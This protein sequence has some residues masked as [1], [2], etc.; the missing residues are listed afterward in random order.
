[1]HFTMN[2]REWVKNFTKLFIKSVQVWPNL[3][4]HIKPVLGICVAKI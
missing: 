2:A 3:V 1:M 4:L